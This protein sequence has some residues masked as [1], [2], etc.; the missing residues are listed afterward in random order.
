M[1]LRRHG[2]PSRRGPS[3]CSAPPLTLHTPRTHHPR[4]AGGDITTGDGTGG[5]SIYGESWADENFKLKHDG[6]GRVAM[7]NA[8][9]DTNSSQARGWG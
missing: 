5:D 6:P 9:P 8:G 7:A 4:D 2:R 3:C 1:A